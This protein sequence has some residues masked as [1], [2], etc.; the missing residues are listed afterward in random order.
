MLGLQEEEEGEGEVELGLAA[1]SARVRTPREGR[2]CRSPAG[3]LLS[4]M[5]FFLYLGLGILQVFT[6]GGGGFQGLIAKGKNSFDVIFYMLGAES[7]SS[8]E[9]RHRGRQSLGNKSLGRQWETL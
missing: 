1:V 4:V 9:E 2:K 3:T 6:L 5:D 8:A 7:N